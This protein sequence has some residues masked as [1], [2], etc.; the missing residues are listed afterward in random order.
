MDARRGI[1]TGDGA[2]DRAIT[3]QT[4][5]DPEANPGFLVTPGHVFPIRAAEGG[6]LRRVGHTEA[7]V[8]LAALAGLPPAGVLAQILREDGSPASG[9][10]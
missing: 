4:L 8:D 10:A 1:H 2:H 7:A 6:V 9:D 3:I 5:I